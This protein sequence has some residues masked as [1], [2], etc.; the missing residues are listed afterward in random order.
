MSDSINPITTIQ[1]ESYND[2]SKPVL[3]DGLLIHNPN[4]LRQ[5]TIS[6]NSSNAYAPELLGSSSKPVSNNVDEKKEHVETIKE[7]YTEKELGELYYS[8]APNNGQFSSNNDEENRKQRK[9]DMDTEITYPPHHPNYKPT[10]K[11]IVMSDTSQL[12]EQQY[13][14]LLMTVA[15]TASLGIIVFM[16]TSNSTSAGP[17]P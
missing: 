16:L 11:E 4:N 13:N 5:Q 3:I 10:D 15:A 1:Y 6:G 9:Y 2:I 12:M 7:G 14:T 17:S 8:I